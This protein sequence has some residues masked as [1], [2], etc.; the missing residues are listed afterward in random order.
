MEKTTELLERDFR[1]L[2][3]VNLVDFD[4]KYGHRQDPVG[5]ANALN[6]FDQWLGKAIPMLKEDDTLIITADH[7]C[8]PTDNS[9]DH[10]R[11]YVPC[12]VYGKKINPANLGTIPGFDHICNSVYKLLEE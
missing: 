5:Y 3:F 6:E 10:T 4:M 2:C 1:G 9:T 8:D 12:F 7:G 11:E